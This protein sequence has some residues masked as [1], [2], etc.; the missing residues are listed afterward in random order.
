MTEQAQLTNRLGRIVQFSPVRMA[1]A[2]VWLIA[3]FT[4]AQSAVELL[5]AQGTIPVA[6]LSVTVVVSIT[7]LAYAAFVRTIEKRPVSEFAASGAV[8]ELANG[9]L[10]GAALFTITIGILWGLGYY[11]ITGVND[12]MIAVPALAG[13]LISGMFEETLF[14]GILFRMV[15]ER[16]GTWLALLISALLFGLL[17]LGNPNATWFAAVAIALE[18]GVLLAAAYVLTRRL[19]LAIGIHLAWN[20]TQGGVFGVAVSGNQAG[21]LLQSSLAGPEFLSGGEFGAEASIVA[22]LVCAA[23]GVYLLWRAQNKG[24]FMKPFWRRREMAK[25]T[26]A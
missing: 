18:A 7:Y 16:L 3:M 5:P 15:E 10:V 6:A 1:L 13:A 17:H 25:A 12:W 23:A 21:G 26:S 4:I 9:V 8:A 22:V 11:T 19:W 2:S 14:R 20:F 24:H